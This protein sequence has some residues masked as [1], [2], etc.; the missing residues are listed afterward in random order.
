MKDEASQIMPEIP[1][2]DIARYPLPGMAQPGS[3]AFSPDDRLVTFLDN[4]EG[5]LVKQLVAFDTQ[6]LQR[7]MLVA[8]Q[9]GGATEENLSLEEKLRRERQR[10]LDL[11]VTSYQWAKHTNQI[12]LPFPDGVYVLDAESKD[13]HKLV[14]SSA[15]PVLDARF[16]PDGEW[17][18]YVQCSELYIV[19]T[20]GG[21]PTRMTFWAGEGL[22]HGLAEFMAQEEMDRS[23]GYWWS[24]DSRMLAFEEVDESHI[25][26]YRIVHQ[27][28]EITGENAQ[29]DHRYPFAG[30]ANAHV[31]LGVVTFGSDKPVW[32][33]L[34]S[35]LDIYL[36]RAHWLPDGRLLAE[37]LNRRQTV[38][39]LL[40]FDPRV[41]TSTLVLREDSSVWINLNNLFHPIE[42]G[43]Y[44]GGFIW[45]SERS[46][47]LH[48]YLYDREGRLV[49]A[50]THGEWMVDALAGV[51][52][53][54]GKIFF[55]AGK[56]SPLESQ[57]YAVSLDGGE[58]RQITREPG[59]H[60]VV[61][62]HACNRFVDVFQSINQPPRV[63]LRSASDGSELA[64]IHETTDD[65]LARLALEPPEL[66]RLT[67]RTGDLLYGAI[68]RPPAAFGPGPY[69]V[70]VSVY[71]GPHAQMVNNAW[72]MTI[73]MR[74]QA[75]R[76]RGY[77]VFVLDNRGSARRGL[78]FEGAIRHNMGDVEV[79]DQVDGVRWLVAQGLADPKRVGIYG[80][81]YGGYMTLMC[82]A[83]APEVF[84][85]G[86]AGAPVSHWDG[87]DTC[88]TERYMGL[89]QENVEG[90]R[91]SSVMEH[92][93]QMQGKLLLVHGLIDENV[94]FRH[95]AR[96][97][98][99]M[100]R[101]RKHYDLFL[102]PDERHS[103]RQ[104]ADRVYMEEQIAAFFERALA[105]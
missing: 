93:N 71:G 60:S 81:S 52:E 63:T 59:M 65:R 20:R 84:K 14:D 80:W 91:V 7:Q 31:R 77:L 105:D 12:L 10:Q 96:L 39:D 45:G 27:G 62:D 5:S 98:N 4:V 17:T 21:E 82:L 97:I 35:D 53:A 19:P 67:N 26:V 34:G 99:A 88:Y 48:L 100:I 15:G 50:L 55:T 9:A 37:V 13:L 75:L 44:S 6:T 43:P 40:C 54:G 64:V 28:K 18:A 32:M 36:A 33:D 79:Q 72:R 16:S 61:L 57:L 90:Y 8:P 85:C 58:P 38:L 101:A 83:R 102:F 42:S 47:F 49:R 86:V 92:V 104:L 41:G 23:Q 56:D 95:T 3:L 68:Y 94:H 24:P 30:Q 74:A 1:F 89:P 70:V 103:P 51:D 87:Y 22:T 78:A 11:G 25:P 69:P 2:E 76:R 66:V 46:G 73:S 29:E